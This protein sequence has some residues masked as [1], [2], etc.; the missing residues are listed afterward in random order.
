MLSCISYLNTYK[1]IKS[2]YQTSDL[3]QLRRGFLDGNRLSNTQRN[4]HI[5][6][7]TNSTTAFLPFKIPF[8]IQSSLSFF[9]PEFN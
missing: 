8:M 3:Y 7:L 6:P 2:H 9:P 4:T 5:T 1:E